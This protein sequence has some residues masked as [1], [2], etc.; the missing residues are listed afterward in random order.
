MS[1][2]TQSPA[3]RALSTHRKQLAGIQV[4][5][6]FAADSARASRM[7]LE[8]GEL[9][10]DYSRNLATPETVRLLLAL[11]D[12]AGVREWVRR[13]FAGDRI[14]ST[15]DRPV[16]HVA[17]RSDRTRFPE[18]ADVLPKVREVL[19]RMRVI[20]EQARS[21]AL[22]GATGKPVR[23]FVNIGIGG[24]DLG[25]RML[26]LALRAYWG[27]GPEV[28]FVANADPSDI[29]A[30]LRGLDPETTFFIVTSKTFTTEETMENARRARLWLEGALPAG[31]DAGAQFIGVTASV[32]RA[33]AFGIGIERILAIWEW[34]G[35]RFSLW[36]AVGLPV[37]IAIGMDRFD[38]LLEGARDMDAHFH[39]APLER[40]MPVILALLT[41]WYANFWDA[42]TR[43]V[44]PYV[45]NLR[46]LPAYLQ[47]LEMESNGKRID[48]D[49]HEVDYA[50]SPI[51]WGAGGTPSQ[52]SFHQLLHQGTHL[53]PVE[54]VLAGG[55]GSGREAMA[56]NAV[57]QAVA[58]MNG[59]SSDD[60]PHRAHPGNRPSS[61]IVLERLAPEALGQLLAMYEHRV[62]VEGI[63]WNIDS[64][65]QWGVEL[66]KHLARMLLPEFRGSGAAAPLDPAARGVIERIRRQR[67]D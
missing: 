57:A 48:R 40:N 16:L 30:A 43:A 33:H 54:F 41:V 47:Q 39:T 2:L 7:S 60:A 61:T 64:F 29:E 15:E 59:D 36:S 52:H 19:A 51:I 53:V 44:I 56:A 11:A 63:I 13:M 38:A 65:D 25:P 1:T 24:S 26:T 45:E 58:L 23:S 35:G 42:Q 66:G 32:E 37:A 18:D 5:D 10:L 67:P 4:R 12:Q 62:F 17:L 6:L 21:G 55:P 27:G 28:R 31:A 50:T 9:F 22:R 14:N 8:F 49:G 46:E 34:V 3:W 20:V